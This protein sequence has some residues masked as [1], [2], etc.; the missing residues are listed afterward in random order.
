MNNPVIVIIAYNREKSLRRLLGSLAKA[1]YP[2]G[3]VSLI[4]SIDGGGLPEVRQAADDFLWEHGEKTV[5][6]RDEAL[7]LKKHV[8]LCSS[9]ASE[10]GSAIILEDDLYVARDFYHYALAALAYSESSDEADRIAGV[11]LYNHLLNV[12]VREP[13]EAVNDGFDNWYF[14]FASSWGQ[15]YTARQWEA[16]ARWLEKNDNTPF[17]D[18]IPQFVRSWSDEKSWLKYFI[19]YVVEKDR[20]FIYPR[21]SRSTNFGDEGTHGVGQ[22]NDLQVPLYQG[23][24]PE[25]Y[26]FSSLSSSKSVYDAFFENLSLEKQLKADGRSVRVDLY[27]AKGAPDGG[28]LYLTNRYDGKGKLLRSYGRHLRPIDAN[29]FDEVEGEDFFLMD[30]D[31]PGTGAALTPDETEKYLYNYRAFKAKYGVAIIRRRLFR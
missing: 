25:G 11:S 9:Y 15:A 12:H 8:L 31:E 18:E 17:G 23:E 13:F 29:I 2:D 22:C 5:I 10:Y 28:G 4:I 20:Y 21:I 24:V 7:G 27:G 14:Q 1:S 6:L 3:G 19:R 30:T 16:F 26:T